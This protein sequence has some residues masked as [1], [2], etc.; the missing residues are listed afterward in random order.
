MEILKLKLCHTFNSKS[1]E[2]LGHIDEDCIKK[3]DTKFIV[4]ELKIFGGNEIREFSDLKSALAYSKD[5]N[6]VS[7]FIE[8]TNKEAEMRMLILQY[9]ACSDKIVGYQNFFGIGENWKL[10]LNSKADIVVQNLQFPENDITVRFRNF[11]T[12]NDFYL[13]LSCLIYTLTNYKLETEKEIRSTLLQVI[14][15]VMK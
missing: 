6:L 1:E 11:P 13:N 8:Y 2:I 4:V 10:Y 14:N 5:H 3:N 7:R 15:N 9:V 12:G